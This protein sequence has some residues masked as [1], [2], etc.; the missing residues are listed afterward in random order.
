MFHGLAFGRSDA[1]F[2]L[3]AAALVAVTMANDLDLQQHVTDADPPNWE[4]FGS[5]AFLAPAAL[6]LWGAGKLAHHDALTASTTRGAIAVTI[7]GTVT[8]AVKE[9]CGRWRP[10]E[11]PDDPYQFDPFSGHASF[12]SGHTTLAFAAATAIDRETGSIWVPIVAYP[13]AALVGWS[14]VA[15]REHWTSDVVAGA[16][17]GYWVTTKAEDVLRAKGVGGPVS[18]A[19]APGP[20]GGVASVALRF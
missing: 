19:W 5:P 1:L 16:A 3:G 8:V 6:V 7:A 20:G 4:L 17:I 12:P 14:R 18:V 15:D 10:R 9:I 11:S 2:G 13:V